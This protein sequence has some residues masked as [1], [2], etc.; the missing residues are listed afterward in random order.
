LNTG[1]GGDDEEHQEGRRQ[2]KGHR[3]GE[4]KRTLNKEQVKNPFLL[5]CCFYLLLSSRTVLTFAK[6]MK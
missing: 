3:K 6:R 5:L 2:E 1:H 4:G